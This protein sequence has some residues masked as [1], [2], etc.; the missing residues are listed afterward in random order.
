MT[1]LT[2]LLK[3]I[4]S[5]QRELQV[6][7]ERCSVLMVTSPDSVEEAFRKIVIICD[8]QFQRLCQAHSELQKQTSKRLLKQLATIYFMESE[9]ESD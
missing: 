6:E 8:D 2:E 3:N 5:T 7:I 9:L 4:E 1:T